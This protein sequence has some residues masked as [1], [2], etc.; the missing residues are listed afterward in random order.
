MT[1]QEVKSCS[2]LYDLGIHLIQEPFERFVAQ[3]L[4]KPHSV[5]DNSTV[6]PQTK[7]F[8]QLHHF[9]LELSIAELAVKLKA[10]VPNYF[11]SC[12]TNIARSHHPDFCK[13]NVISQH[14]IHS[15]PPLVR[16][17]PVEHVDSVHSGTTCHVNF[18]TKHESK[19]QF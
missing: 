3:A 2:G 11:Q 12:R 14:G 18:K 5:R 8:F 15:G 6:H 17:P 1:S 7:I 13:A 19:D 10:A 9:F 16:R 4:A